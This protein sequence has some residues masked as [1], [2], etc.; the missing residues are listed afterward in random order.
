[1]ASLSDAG[2]HSRKDRP[3]FI[4]PWFRG[5]WAYDEPL[6][7]G[8]EVFLGHDALRDAAQTMFEGGIIVPQIV[9]VNLNPPIAR[10]DPGHVDI[11]AFRGVDRTRYRGLAPGD[12]AEVRSLRPVVRAERHGGGLVLRGRRWWLHLLAG[13]PRPDPDQPTVHQ[14]LGGGW[15]QR[16]HVPPRRGRGP[17]RTHASEEA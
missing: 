12:D 17:R 15:R 9:Y 10:V 1:M 3:M 14:Q 7:Q 2:K 8:V 4:A 11:P 5:N 13:W 16:L 6:V